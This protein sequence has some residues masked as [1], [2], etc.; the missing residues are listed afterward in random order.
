[1]KARNHGHGILRAILLCF[2]R[3]NICFGQFGHNSNII[4]RASGVDTALKASNATQPVQACDPML[5][6]LIK[7]VS[8]KRSKSSFLEPETLV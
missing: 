3:L 2:L 7:P 8:I 4:F 6:T 5:G 1:M